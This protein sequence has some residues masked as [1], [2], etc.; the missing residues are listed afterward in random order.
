MRRDNFVEILKR[1]QEDELELNLTKGREYAGG[2][3]DALANFKQAGEFIS[4]RC[5]ECGCV[6]K[7]GSLSALMV[8]AFKHFCSLTSYA[9]VGEE[10]S[11]EAIKGRV[12]DLRLYAALF[13]ALVEEQAR[14]GQRQSR[15]A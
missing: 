1:L 10:L 11:D 9:G 15:P 7:I 3:G 5:P 8:Y 4:T 6:H 2:D 12:A 13:E 14:V